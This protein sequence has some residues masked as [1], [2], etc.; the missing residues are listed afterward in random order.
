MRKNFYGYYVDYVFQCCGR[1]SKEAEEA[2]ESDEAAAAPVASTLAADGTDDAAEKKTTGS[3]SDMYVTYGSILEQALR[4]GLKCSPSGRKEQ[5]TAGAA[6]P[7]T[8][9]AALDSGKEAR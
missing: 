4:N 6:A 7:T 5:A 8:Q 2:K 9:G 3:E 1:A